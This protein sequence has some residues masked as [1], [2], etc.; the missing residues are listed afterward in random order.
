MSYLKSHRVT[1]HG[2]VHPV[3][4]KHPALVFGH[5]QN[6]SLACKLHGKRL[7]REVLCRVSAQTYSAKCLFHIHRTISVIYRHFIC[8]YP[9]GIF[10][11]YVDTSFS[12]V[13]SSATTLCQHDY[14][15]TGISHFHRIVTTLSSVGNGISHRFA[16]IL[17]AFATK[18]RRTSYCN[19]HTFS[20]LKGRLQLEVIQIGN[21][22]RY[23]PIINSQHLCRIVDRSCSTAIEHQLLIQN[24]TCIIRCLKRER[25]KNRTIR[26]R[27]VIFIIL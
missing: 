1:Q 3:G 13:F 14:R 6:L 2:T 21:T 16:E 27:H 23:C 7:L 15:Q 8:F 5:A 10:R 22:T 26:Y 24:L 11:T 19:C 20:H 18:L 17:L 12:P 9:I 4:Q 25:C